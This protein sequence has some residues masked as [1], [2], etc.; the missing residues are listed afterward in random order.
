MSSIGLLFILTLYVSILFILP[1]G[2]KK[3]V[4][5]N[6]LIIRTS[7]PFLLLFIVL[8]GLIMEA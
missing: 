3:E 7:T 1:I 8:H 2:Q 5:L 6:G 4:T